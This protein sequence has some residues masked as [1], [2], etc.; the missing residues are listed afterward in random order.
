M[1]DLGT[2]LLS[3]QSPAVRD[4]L[5][6]AS[7]ALS[8]A[9]LDHSLKGDLFENTVIDFI[10]VLG[11]DVERQ[12]F[13]ERYGYTSYLSALVKMAQM[14]VVEKAVQMADDGLVAQ[15]AD[16]LDDMRERF[17]L[18]GVR[19]PFGWISRLRTYGKKVQNNTT[20][21]GY[22]YW[23]DDEQTLSYKGLRLTMTDFQ[24]F[25]RTPVTLAQSDLGQ[26]FLLH[27]DRERET[28]VP[29]LSLHQLQN[30]PAHNQR[31][32]NSLQDPR[33]LLY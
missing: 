30:N 8:I 4:Q 25:A 22:I 24:R 17:L 6:H 28:V 26:L 23:S 21:L 31:G 20:S 27:E 5:D 3:K 33:N 29:L 15:P 13:R 7:L 11:V 1:E 2:R 19:A 12:T 14:L 32:W 18:Y 10:A 9:L 16:A